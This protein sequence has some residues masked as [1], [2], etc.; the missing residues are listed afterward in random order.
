MS[1]KKPHSKL[2]LYFTSVTFATILAFF[3]LITI[4]GFIL[5]QF[6]VAGTDPRIRHVPIFIFAVGSVLLGVVIALF[7]GKRIIRPIERLDQAFKEISA[8][9]F[10][11]RLSEDEPIREMREMAQQFNAMVF[12]L[13][14]IETLRSDFVANVSHE[15]KTP[16]AAIEGYATLL[17]NRNLPP[18]KQDRYIEKILDNS[19]RLSSLSGNILMLSKLEN[20]EMIPDKTEYR[21]DEQ[22]RK[23]I[24]MPEAKW[25]ENASNLTWSCPGR[26][27]MAAQR[28]LEQV[29][30]NLIDNAIKH[31]PAD[32]SIHISICEK[33]GSIAVSIADDGEGMTAEV[34]KH[35]FEKFYQGETS[36]K[37]EGNG[38]GLAL[39]KRITDLCRGSIQ[40]ESSPGS[41]ST[42]IV[43]LP[44]ET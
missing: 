17:Q 22:I 9:N 13:S 41:G 19:R 21:L 6:G 2:W 24:L 1:D 35:I 11:V 7:V 8:G 5:Y 40:V 26:T 33:A 36:H 4:L 31:S 18:E 12:D 3:I 16:I 29:W 27:T 37:A 25:T 10:S 44:R 28:L 43:V 14:H 34:Q 15:F 38:L 20:Q 30:I 42:F 32:S 23:C 39:V